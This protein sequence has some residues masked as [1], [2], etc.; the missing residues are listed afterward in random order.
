MAARHTTDTGMSRYELPLGTLLAAVRPPV[1][2]KRFA[3]PKPNTRK[4]AVPI[5]ASWPTA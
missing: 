5:P 1:R 4:I 3:A 2:P